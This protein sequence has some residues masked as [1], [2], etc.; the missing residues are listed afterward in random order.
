MKPHIL[1]Y[2]AVILS[3]VSIPVT[4]VLGFLGLL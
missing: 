2:S 1:F 4:L 3:F